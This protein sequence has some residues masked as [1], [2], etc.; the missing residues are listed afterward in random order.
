[1]KKI[2]I[3]LLGL[4]V[5]ATLVTGQYNQGSYNIPGS[6]VATNVVNIFTTNQNIVLV[7]LT[8]SDTVGL[9]MSNSTAATTNLQ[10]NSPSLRW[11]G[12]GFKTTATAG[13]QPVYF[14]SYVV[15]V[16]GA[17]NPTALWTL[18]SNI[19]GGALANLLT[20][21]SDGSI[22][23]T[24]TGKILGPAQTVMNG[25]LS[26]RVNGL[27]AE[28]YNI[29]VGSGS[30]VFAGVETDGTGYANSFIMN[31][32]GGYA[33]SSE[34]SDAT[35]G[36][37]RG[38]GD[39]IMLRRSAGIVGFQG[40]YTSNN[41]VCVGISSATNGF[42]TYTNSAVASSAI[43]FPAS[44]ANWTNTFGINITLYIDNS[45]VTGTT[46]SKNGQQIFSSLL[47]DVTLLFK[48]GDYFSTHYTVGTPTARWEPR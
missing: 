30:L 29:G 44:D 45:G 47:G 5:V 12:N 22:T 2:L 41:V 6:G 26:V 48:P 13:S 37:L 14:D 25:V 32:A 1:M 18:G 8:N 23:M 39:T 28:G 9:S 46:T 10:Q 38:A 31:S 4:T 34:V 42:A 17:A 11:A 35:L 3:P 16:Q 20:Y 24:G 19:N 7:N 27:S 21:G 43:T 36:G 15:P 33:F 40:I